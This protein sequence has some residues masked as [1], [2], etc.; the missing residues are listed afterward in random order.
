MPS[1]TMDLVD[2]EMKNFE[3]QMIK[4]KKSD[5][6]KKEDEDSDLIKSKASIISGESTIYL[7][8]F[9]VTTLPK[10]I[11]KA[12][13][14][15]PEMARKAGIEGIVVLELDINEKGQVINIKV[16][17][18]GGFGFDQSAIEAIKKTKFSP[19][20]KYGKP[21]PIRVRLPVKFELQ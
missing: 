9:E 6:I 12:E 19:A 10:I 20:L 18:S 11:F 14:K 8:V 5:N 3:N 1:T 16:V 7:P 21:V 17:R 13:P 2:I 4:I 15:Y